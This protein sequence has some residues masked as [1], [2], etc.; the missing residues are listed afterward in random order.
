MNI[1]MLQSQ[2]PYIKSIVQK[3]RTDVQNILLYNKI[4]SPFSPILIQF[5]SKQQ[6]CNLKC[7]SAVKSGG[8][9]PAIFHSFRAIGLEFLAT[10]FWHCPVE[11][12]LGN[13]GQQNSCYTQTRFAFFLLCFDIPHL[14]FRLESC[15]SLNTSA[16]FVK[17][18]LSFPLLDL[19]MLEYFRNSSS[20]QLDQRAL[21]LFAK[22]TWFRLYNYTFRTDLTTMD[23][24]SL[25]FCQVFEE[26]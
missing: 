2:E 6:V 12:K 9:T 14:I 7:T 17:K 23:I 20:F 18:I 4:V 10:G 26:V 5:P 25:G 19:T 24:F 3:Y 13:L 1:G 16:N 22:L 21:C 11:G 15:C 8:L